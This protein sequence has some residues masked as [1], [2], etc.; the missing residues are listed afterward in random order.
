MIG[1]SAQ[2]RHW[3]D[4]ITAS[5]C[6]SNR[7]E[8]ISADVWTLRSLIL[9]NTFQDD[10]RTDGIGGVGMDFA[11]LNR[12]TGDFIERRENFGVVEEHGFQGS[13]IREPRSRHRKRC[14]S[15]G[16]PMT[17]GIGERLCQLIFGPALVSSQRVLLWLR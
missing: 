16:L 6:L 1:S 11:D 14:D 4:R 17:I 2:Y 8:G 3:D 12:V 5:A 7:L 10:C 9:R 15:E 13:D